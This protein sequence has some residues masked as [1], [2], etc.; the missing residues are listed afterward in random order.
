MLALFVLDSC[1]LIYKRGVITEKFIKI[2]SIQVYTC[3]H[4]DIHEHDLKWS[5]FYS[6]D[7]M[8]SYSKNRNMIN[9]K[10]T[11]SL[12]RIESI[13]NK[14]SKLRDVLIKNPDK[15]ENNEKQ[16]HRNVLFRIYSKNKI[17]D[18]RST[19]HYNVMNVYEVA[20]Y[21]YNGHH[22]FDN[23]NKFYKEKTGVLDSLYKIYFDKVE[24]VLQKGFCDDHLK[25]KF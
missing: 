5:C 22:D 17:H 10:D 1:S 4:S 24:R 20:Q 8:V 16:Y 9:I 13:V 14:K 2:D 25:A 18:I 23:G 15:F 3:Y 19:H 11:F 21:S 12:K 7:S 6:P